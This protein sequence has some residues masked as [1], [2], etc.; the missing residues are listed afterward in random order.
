MFAWYQGYH[1]CSIKM[2]S[3]ALVVSRCLIE[4]IS[5]VPPWQAFIQEDLFFLLFVFPGKLC[6]YYRVNHKTFVTVYMLLNNNVF[7]K[8][9]C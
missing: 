8:E 1:V 2:S 5:K 7:I 6:V 9:T 4:I 3:F